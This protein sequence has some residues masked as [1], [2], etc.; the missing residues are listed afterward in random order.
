MK[1]TATA[2]IDGV[3]FPCKGKIIILRIKEP[4]AY[5]SWSLSHG[6]QAIAGVSE[7]YFYKSALHS[8][9]ELVERVLEKIRRYRMGRK[10]IFENV[11]ISS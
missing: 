7:N 5:V 1:I 11:Q 4:Q 8:Q 6:R 10:S 3:R 9:E 2:I